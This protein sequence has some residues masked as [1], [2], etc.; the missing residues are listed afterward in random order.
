MA[1]DGKQKKGCCEKFGDGLSN[2]GT[3]LYNSE[4]GTVMGRTG[5][6]WLKIG[7]FYLIFYGFLAAF[8]SAMLTVFLKTLND[9]ETGKGP[10]LVQFLENKPGLTYKKG[11]WTLKKFKEATD[12]DAKLKTEY[13]SMVEDILAKYNSSV[14]CPDSKDGMKDEC[15]F[16]VNKLGACGPAGAGNNYGFDDAKPCAYVRINKVFGWVPEPTT[17]GGSFLDLDCGDKTTGFDVFPQGFHI[18][19]FP[20]RGQKDFELPLVAVQIDTTKLTKVV[21]KLVGPNIE[22][23]ESVQ[24][25]RAFAKVEIS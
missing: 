18:G 2:F 25:H 20:F 22:V 9:V 17:E 7:F 5:K 6:S 10:K 4:A 14:L 8:F 3:F 24:A 15:R 12:K 13:V 23:S 11:K 19:S 21:C 1:D 16:D